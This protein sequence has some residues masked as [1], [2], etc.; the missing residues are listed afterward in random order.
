MSE[1]GYNALLDGTPLWDEHLRVVSPKSWQRLVAARDR[2]CVMHGPDSEV[3]EEPFAAHH[4]ITQ[5]QLRNRHLS[6]FAWDVRNGMW[7]CY[8]AHRRHHSGHERIP[9]ELIPARAHEFAEELGLAWIL[10]RFYP[11]EEAA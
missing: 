2:H 1:E 4:L 6:D 8:R 3:C 9:Y 11:K 7:L 5:Q 10:D